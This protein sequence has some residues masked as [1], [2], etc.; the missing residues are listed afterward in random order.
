MGTPEDK[1]QLFTIQENDG[2]TLSN[3]AL[4]LTVRV[5]P[6]RAIR[7]EWAGCEGF[8]WVRADN[9]LRRP[10]RRSSGQKGKID[11][12]CESPGDPG[13]CFYGTKLADRTTLNSRHA[14]PVGSRTVAKSGIVGKVVAIWEVFP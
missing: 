10:S 11:R 3:A 12:R 2:W 7:G 8:A 4:G 6:E 5:L 13:R 14:L 1:I 9:F